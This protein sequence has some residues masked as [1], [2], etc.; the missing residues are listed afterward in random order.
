MEE[1]HIAKAMV[2]S[3]REQEG[4]SQAAHQV[5]HRGPFSLG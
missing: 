5:G 3:R 2:T 4:P 1:T